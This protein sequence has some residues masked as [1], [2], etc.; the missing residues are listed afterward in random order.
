MR[1]GGQRPVVADIPRLL[2]VVERS[3]HWERIGM[4]HEHVI[5]QILGNRTVQLVT[6]IMGTLSA[7]LMITGLL[8]RDSGDHLPA[9]WEILGFVGVA[10]ALLSMPPQTYYWWMRF[11]SPTR[12]Q[13]TGDGSMPNRSQLSRLLERRRRP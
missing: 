2:G 1:G 13:A 7:P 4:S 5:G 8:M 3:Y 12:R 9:V 6:R 10:L 11:L